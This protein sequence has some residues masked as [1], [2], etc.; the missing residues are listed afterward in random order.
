MA[1]ELWQ[2]YLNFAWILILIF[3]VILFVLTLI[4][5][6]HIAFGKGVLCIRI[7]SFIILEMELIEGEEL[8]KLKALEKRQKRK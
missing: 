4:V 1:H 8:K 6:K 2:S 7:G 5:A 3:T